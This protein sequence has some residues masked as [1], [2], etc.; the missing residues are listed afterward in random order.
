MQYLHQ[1]NA[2][3]IISITATKTPSYLDQKE[4]NYIGIILEN[5]TYH[6]TV[7]QNLTEFM[8]ENTENALM[9]YFSEKNFESE[10]RLNRQTRFP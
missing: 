6:N 5:P 7:R 8:N 2:R 4:I 9:V 1:D 3:K 10:F